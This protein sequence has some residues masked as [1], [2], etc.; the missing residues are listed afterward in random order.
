[1]KDTGGRD[2]QATPMPTDMNARARSLDVAPRSRRCVRRWCCCCSSALAAIPGSIVPQEDVDSLGA[3]RWQ[4]AHPK[5]TPVYEK[6]G[7]FS[8]YDSPWFSAIYILLMISLVGC[9][10]PRTAVYWRA[11]RAEPPRRRGTCRGCPSTRRT[12]QKTLPTTCSSGQRRS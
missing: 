11:L 8:V 5:L 3:S 10:V 7:L 2:R 4:D 12:R 1:M 6:L 9:I